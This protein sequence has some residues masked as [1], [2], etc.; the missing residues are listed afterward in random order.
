MEH[1][2]TTRHGLGTLD[3]SLYGQCGHTFL[4]LALCLVIKQ[5]GHPDDYH[6]RSLIRRGPCYSLSSLLILLWS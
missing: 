1:Y 4:A 2:T 3:R 5:L 6:D